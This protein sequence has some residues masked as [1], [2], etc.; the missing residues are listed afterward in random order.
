[1]V[2]WCLGDVLFFINFWN[3]DGVCYVYVDM[4]VDLE[5]VKNIVID[6]KVDYLVVCNVLVCC[7]YELVF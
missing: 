2:F 4:V 7:G 1:M 6:L 3:V 5:K